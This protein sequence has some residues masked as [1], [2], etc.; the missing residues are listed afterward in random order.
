MPAG[1]LTFETCFSP[2]YLIYSIAVSIDLYDTMSCTRRYD[3]RYYY[4]LM[5]QRRYKAALCLGQLPL[6]T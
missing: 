5:I 6:Q 2:L 4:M 3:T 1:A